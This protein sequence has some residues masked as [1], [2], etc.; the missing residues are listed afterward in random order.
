MDEPF[1]EIPMP[2]KFRKKPVEITAWQLTRHNVFDLA[3]W[4]N[5]RGTV[6]EGQP[7]VFIKTL[8][9]VMR[10]GAGDWV[11]RGVEGE[12]YPCKGSIFEQTYEAA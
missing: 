11:I 10:A 5:G 7:Y 3:E 6:A 4:C 12:F 1:I 2:A 8:E 9:G